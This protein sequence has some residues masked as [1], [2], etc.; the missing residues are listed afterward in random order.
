MNTAGYAF[1]LRP[2]GF[3]GRPVMTGNNCAPPYLIDAPLST[4]S[5]CPVVITDSSE[6][7]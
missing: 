2:A 3:G 5:T 7:R 6:A 1:R 4:E